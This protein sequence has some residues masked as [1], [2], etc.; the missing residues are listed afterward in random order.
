MQEDVLGIK[1]RAHERR[2]AESRS[3]GGVGRVSSGVQALNKR[4]SSLCDYKLEMCYG[5]HVCSL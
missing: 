2:D 1:S 5:Y 4:G 3:L